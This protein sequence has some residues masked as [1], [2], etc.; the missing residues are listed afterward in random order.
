MKAPNTAT[1]KEAVDMEC[2]VTTVSGV[3]SRVDVVWSFNGTEI[4]RVEAIGINY[5]TNSSTVYSHVY[6]VNLTEPGGVYQCEAII[7]I[8]PPMKAYW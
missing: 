7:N 5:T 6:K 8:N 4:E 1:V 3:K 2:S